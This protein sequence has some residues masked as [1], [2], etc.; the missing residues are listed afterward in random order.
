MILVSANWSLAVG[1]CEVIRRLGL[2]VQVVGISWK[3]F[4]LRQSTLI[5]LAEWKTTRRE[6]F[7]WSLGSWAVT[8][9]GVLEVIPLDFQHVAGGVM[10]TAFHRALTFS[11]L[12]SAMLLQT[13][14]SS[15][16]NLRSQTTMF[17]CGARYF[18][19][20]VLL[21]CFGMR[22]MDGGGVRKL[23]TFSIQKENIYVQLF[24]V[25]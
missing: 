6:V 2:I 1:S 12:G 24:G 20:C 21:G 15:R 16:P 19:P 14:G 3:F 4:W 5:P 17:F 23:P 8:G 10:N 9:F 22:S 7:R 18:S 11:Q 13:V 25:I